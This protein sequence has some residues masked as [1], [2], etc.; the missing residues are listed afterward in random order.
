MDIDEFNEE[1]SFKF[2]FSLNKEFEEWEGLRE[3][4]YRRNIIIHNRN[5]ISSIYMKKMNL[6]PDSL[7]KLTLI[8]IN[9][10]KAASEIIIKYIQFIFKKIIEK[11][12]LDTSVK[13]FAPFPSRFDKSMIVKKGKDEIFN[14]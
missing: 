12:N 2:N 6:P 11:F 3:V 13:R 10:V 5:M 1:I 4:Y 7:N 8:D 14:D 9:Y